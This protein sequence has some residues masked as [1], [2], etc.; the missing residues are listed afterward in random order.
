M[1]VSM[2][3]LINNIHYS[4]PTAMIKLLHKI[5]AYDI[6][7]YG[8]D[9]NSIGYSAGSMLVD[10][11]FRMPSID[12]EDAYLVA[13]NE[14]CEKNNID[15]IFPSTDKEI[16][17]LSKYASKIFTRTVIQSEPVIKIFSDKYRATQKIHELGI[18]TPPIINCLFGEKKVIFRKK[19]SVSSEGI[20]AVDL[21]KE[22]YIENHFSN[23]YFVQ[24]YIEGTE[25]TVDIFADINGVPKLIIPRKR[26]EIKNGMSFICQLKKHQELIDACQTICSK[27]HLP[28]L[29]NIQFIDDGNDI[30]FIELNM[31]FAGSG[32]SGIVGSFNYFKQYIDHFIYNKPLKTMDY[33]MSKVAWDSII[34]RYFEE[35][36]Y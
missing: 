15:F 35:C 36:I 10:K 12:N 8:T 25:Y 14:L 31:R 23:D 13:L 11:Y 26:L 18:K 17:F 19:L 16:R 27:Y 29:F 21:S 20:Y 3:I 30:Y 6:S 7:V 9:T 28:G 22:K 4:N 2:N 24:H 32:I 33:Y 5:K 1:R 34:T